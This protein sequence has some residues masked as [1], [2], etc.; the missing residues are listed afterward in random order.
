MKAQAGILDSAAD[1][2]IKLI[3]GEAYGLIVGFE[4]DDFNSQTVTPKLSTG[5]NTGDQAQGTLTVDT[6][7]TAGDTFTIGNRIY[8]F[9]AETAVRRKASE[10]DAEINIGTDLATTQANIIAAINGT[11]DKYLADPAVSAAAFSSNASVITA[12]AA[13]LAGNAIATTETFTAVT[14]VFDAATLGTTTAGTDSF[15]ELVA[16]PQP[17]SADSNGSPQAFSAPGMI[18]FDAILPELL[19]V[20]SGAVT[21]VNYRLTRIEAY[22]K[23]R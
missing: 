10:R 23:H 11:G 9:L 6:Q 14:N 18:T 21:S 5:K 22:R 17:G 20:T 19:L 15:G 4:G 16:I 7:P 12:R 1:T 3:Q 13:G 2:R 8:F